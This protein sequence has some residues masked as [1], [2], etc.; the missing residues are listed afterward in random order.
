MHQTLIWLRAAAG[1]IEK[2]LNAQLPIAASNGL[3]R[4]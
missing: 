3:R 2:L 1:W 4:S